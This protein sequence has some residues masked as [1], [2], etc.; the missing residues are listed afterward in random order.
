MEADEPRLGLANEPI[1]QLERQDLD[2]FSVEELEERIAAL[3]RE[4]ARAQSRIAS[5]RTTRLAADALF[6]AARKIDGI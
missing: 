5:A 2:R 4:I 1:V 3:Q 6:G